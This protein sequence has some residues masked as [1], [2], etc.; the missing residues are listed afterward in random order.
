MGGD[1]E[2]YHHMV[3]H[4]NVANLEASPRAVKNSAEMKDSFRE[5]PV[6]SN[7]AFL[8]MNLLLSFNQKQVGE[9]L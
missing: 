1:S 8:Q 3:L 5:V 2:T 9:L 6:S 4:S 7:V